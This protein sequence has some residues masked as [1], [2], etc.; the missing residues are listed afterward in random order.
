ML[1]A[2]AGLPDWG[3]PVFLGLPGRKDVGTLID[4]GL[5]PA[6]TPERKAQ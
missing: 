1:L 2:L 5:M 4:Q 3:N 6:P